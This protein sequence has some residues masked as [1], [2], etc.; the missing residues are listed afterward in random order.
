MINLLSLGYMFIIG[1][2]IQ[3]V[4]GQLTFMI[5][6]EEVARHVNSAIMFL[7]Q[8]LGALIVWSVT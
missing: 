5:V 7:S 6:N 8:G 2:C 1:G 4:L 3:M